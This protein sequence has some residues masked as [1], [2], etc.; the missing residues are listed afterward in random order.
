M[1]V[2]GIEQHLYVCMYVSDSLRTYSCCFIPG[3]FVNTFTSRTVRVG[4]QLAA[5]AS[6]YVCK[7]IAV[8][9]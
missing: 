2:G 6:S 7:Q 8:A 4:R 9:Y 1:F 3:K 5:A